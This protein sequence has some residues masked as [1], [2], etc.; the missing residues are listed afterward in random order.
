MSPPP[1][2]NQLHR[3]GLRD[4]LNDP[5]ALIA[6]LTAWGA[7]NGYSNAISAPISHPAPTALVAADGQYLMSF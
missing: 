2:F 6:K 4:I 1:S 5:D 3:H 7:E